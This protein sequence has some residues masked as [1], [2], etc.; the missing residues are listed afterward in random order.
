MPELP[1]VET[2]K[3]QLNLR[4]KGKTIKTVEVKLP[5][6]VKYPVKKFKKITEGSTIENISRR[7]KILLFGLSGD[8]VLAVHLKLSGQL[9]FNGESQKHTHLIYYFKDNSKL[10]HNDVRQFG[11]VKVIPKQ[12]LIDFLEKESFGPEPLGK[13]F[14]LDLFKELLKK[15]KKSPI[16]KVLM[17]PKFIAGIGNLYADEILFFAG[18][19]PTRRVYRVNNKE[20]EKIYRQIKRI[21]RLAIKKGGSSSSDYVD[22]DGEK[23]NYLS[24]VKVYQRHGQPCKKCKSE[25]KKTKMNNRSAHYCPKCQK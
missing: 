24:L 11:F 25:I 9:I 8:H 18:V 4:I 14:T 12:K 22:A 5:R 17:D 3:N 1:E 21:L 19:R 2:I 13:E 7:A 20:I 15:R 16:K 10:I 23:G 6:F